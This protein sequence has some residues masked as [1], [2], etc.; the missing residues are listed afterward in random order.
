MRFVNYALLLLF[1]AGLATGCKK[2]E[3]KGMVL[4]GSGTGRYGFVFLLN[5]TDTAGHDILFGEYKKYSKDELKIYYNAE[6]N[7]KYDVARPDS[8]KRLQDD[9]NYILSIIPSPAMYY[10][11][12]NGKVTDSVLFDYSIKSSS[13]CLPPEADIKQVKVNNVV[14]NLPASGI[15]SIVK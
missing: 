12:I 2:D 3:D 13:G 6:G 14:Y 9:Y 7:K 10:I 1:I 8:A 15:V 4:C 11:E 5:F